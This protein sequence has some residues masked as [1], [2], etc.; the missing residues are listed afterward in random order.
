[1]ANLNVFLRYPDRLELRQFSI[2]HIDGIISHDHSIQYRS[3]NDV[4]V[5]KRSNDSRDSRGYNS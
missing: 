3:S 4:Y 5:L 1:M 2:E